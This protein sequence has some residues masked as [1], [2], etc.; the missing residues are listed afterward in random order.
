MQTTKMNLKDPTQLLTPT[1][2][3]SGQTT[4]FEAL[5]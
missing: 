4:L 5:V 3:Q 2:H 1:I